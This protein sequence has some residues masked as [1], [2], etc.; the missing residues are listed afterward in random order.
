L[1]KFD[2]SAS[3]NVK[4]ENFKMEN[5]DLRKRTQRRQRLFSQADHCALLHPLGSEME[6]V[7]CCAAGAAND[8]PGLVMPHC[9]VL[10]QTASRANEVSGWECGSVF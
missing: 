2:L 3:E 8:L 1:V 10:Q 7:P 6:G 5:F 9:F 4:M